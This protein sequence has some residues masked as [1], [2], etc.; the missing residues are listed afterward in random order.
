M[1]YRMSAGMYARTIRIAGTTGKPVRP[2]TR[3]PTHF[4]PLIGFLLAS[5]AS[6]ANDVAGRQ[7]RHVLP[8]FQHGAMF[9]QRDYDDTRLYESTAWAIAR[10][11]VEAGPHWKYTCLATVYAMIE[12]ARGETAYRIG[13]AN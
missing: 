9:D 8:S 13:A 6:G 10:D 5:C 7:D 4:V 3:K 12:H 11:E 1:Q 2:G